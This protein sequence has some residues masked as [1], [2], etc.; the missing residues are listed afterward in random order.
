MGLYFFLPDYLF[1]ALS[2]FNWMNW[3]SP[4]NVKLALISGTVTGLGF[5]PISTFDWNMITGVSPVLISPFFSTANTLMAMLITGIF[6]IPAVYFTNTWYT[7]HLPIN[8]NRVFDN[9]GHLYNASRILSSH[10]LFNETGYQT[11]SP[12]YMSA[13]NAVIYGT[14]FSVYPAT[15]V[16]AYLYH[17]RE[18]KNAF[19][20]LVRRSSN[21]QLNNDVH[22]RLMEQYKEVSEIW[23]FALMAISM[24][25]GIVCVKSYP[26]QTPVWA[27]FFA[28]GLGLVF[29]VPCGIIYA[30]SNVQ[31]TL[32]V[33]AELV[34]G[35][36]IPGNPLSL[37]IIKTYGYIVT[38]RAIS[39]AQDLKLGH[40]VKIPPRTMFISQ[41]IATIIGACVS[42]GVM[43]W[44]IENIEGI[45]T[46]QQPQKFTCPGPNTFFTASA[47]WGILGPAKVYGPGG[48]YHILMW[49][50]FIGGFIPIPFYFFTK[51]YPNSW[52]K[53]VHVP[54]L[55]YGMAGWAPYNLSYIWPGTIVAFIFQVYIRR[56]Y[57]PWWSKY[58][59]VLSTAFTCGVAVA[60]IV[61]FFAFQYKGVQVNWWGNNVSNVGAD[62]EG[63]PLLPIPNKGYFGPGPGEFD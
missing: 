20:A 54:I 26:T 44:Q 34:G 5:N 10:G 18:I 2:T 61:I 28:L 53:Y 17:R 50:F 47:F 48:L 13:A 55:L 7:A 16:Y 32:N 37:D 23:Y 62:G 6:F 39:F 30:V 60:G 49:G 45:C 8:S 56:R 3:I 59:Y 52:V 25:F 1:Q 40:Y 46:R 11:Y 36:A 19:L 38:A 14:F 31:I 15:L 51:R 33:L 42:L 21:S 22:N 24:I 27:I 41:S 58:N 43:N 29:I 9:T 35:F 57:L 4:N 12:M 63:T